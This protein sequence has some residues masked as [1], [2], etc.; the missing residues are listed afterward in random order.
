MNENIM[1]DD[2]TLVK[3][4]KYHWQYFVETNKY[5]YRTIIMEKLTKKYICNFFI[6][7]KKSGYTRKYY[8]EINSF[9]SQKVSKVHLNNCKTILDKFTNEVLLFEILGR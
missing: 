5:Y 4:T 6:T 8:F 3:Q 2:I 1:T 9:N 7:S